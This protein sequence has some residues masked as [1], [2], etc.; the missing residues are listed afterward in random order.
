MGCEATPQRE[1]G[2]ARAHTQDI[3]RSNEI[4]S[5]ATWCFL[6]AP[7]PMT[8]AGTAINVRNEKTATKAILDRF[9]EVLIGSMQVKRSEPKS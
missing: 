4:T 7:P 9:N 8:N 1:P 6:R 5:E 2:R 3:L